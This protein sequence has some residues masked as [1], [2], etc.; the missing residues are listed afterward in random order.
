M[1]KKEIKYEIKKLKIHDDER[2]WFLEIAKASEMKFPIK[3]VSTA[4]IKTGKIR[5]NHYHKKKHDWFCVLGGDAE[6][7]IGDPTGKKVKKI[8]ILENKPVMVHVFPMMA[9]AV[10]NISKNTIYFIEVVSHEYNHRNPDV[11]SC[12]ICK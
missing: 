11:L 8:K 9:H 5:G 1:D 7:F 12:I 6:F 2:G 10:K 3:Q 4:S